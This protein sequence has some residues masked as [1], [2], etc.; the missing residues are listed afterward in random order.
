MFKYKSIKGPITEC[1]SARIAY[2]NI[3][4]PRTN[5]GDLRVMFLVSKTD[6]EDRDRGALLDDQC[7]PWKIYDA[8]LKLAGVDLSKTTFIAVPCD[9]FEATGGGRGID[10]ETGP[11]APN[12]QLQM[13]HWDD[14]DDA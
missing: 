2:R 1:Y 7:L 10:A 5:G 12:Q 6:H 14:E 9:A 4:T 8:V 11:E 3:L 13:Q